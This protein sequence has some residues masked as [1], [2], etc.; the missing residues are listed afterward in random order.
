MLF[1][2]IGSM[3][4]YDFYAFYVAFHFHINMYFLKKQD[5]V[6]GMCY[7]KLKIDETFGV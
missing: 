4:P 3:D 1:L 6:V 7:Y 5:A 2:V